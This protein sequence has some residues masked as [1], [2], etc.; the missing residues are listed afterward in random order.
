[1]HQLLQHENHAI[2]EQRVAQRIAKT[3]ELVALQQKL[4][5]GELAEMSVAQVKASIAL[6]KLAQPH[7]FLCDKPDPLLFVTHQTTS[8]IV[9]F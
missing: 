3:K 1:M 5:P 9:S 4:S 2:I 8:A 6:R 7:W